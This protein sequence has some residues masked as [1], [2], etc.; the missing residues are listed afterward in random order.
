MM[1][2]RVMTSTTSIEPSPLTSAVAKAQLS[3]LVPLVMM[4]PMSETM[5]LMLTRP[6]SVTSP[7][8]LVAQPPETESWT[9]L[10]PIK[11]SGKVAPLA[12]A[13]VVAGRMQYVCRHRAEPAKKNMEI[14][15][16]LPSRRRLQGA[17]YL[18]LRGA[19]KFDEDQLHKRVLWRNWVLHQGECHQRVCNGDVEA[20]SIAET[21]LC[22][23]GRWTGSLQLVA[24]HRLGRREEQGDD[25]LAAHG[26]ERAELELDSCAGARRGSRSGAERNVVGAAIKKGCAEIVAVADTRKLPAK[27]QASAVAAVGSSG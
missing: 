19:A 5:S 16:S 21:A 3:R 2:T 11:V 25:N 15:S 26:R 6:S 13:K 18:A 9:Q 4:M 1:P 10:E 20:K 17:A 22:L 7:L 24:K 14:K 23:L 27:T 12:P 8:P